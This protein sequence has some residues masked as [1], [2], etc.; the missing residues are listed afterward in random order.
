MLHPSQTLNHEQLYHSLCG[1]W[2]VRLSPGQ[3][4]MQCAPVSSHCRD[5]K[6]HPNTPPPLAVCPT[7]SG[8]SVVKSEFSTRSHNVMQT[9]AKKIR[10]MRR[11]VWNLSRKRSVWTQPAKP[12]Q[13]Q[14]NGITNEWSKKRRMEVSACGQMC[15]TMTQ[16]MQGYRVLLHEDLGVWLLHGAGQIEVTMSIYLQKTMMGQSGQLTILHQCMTA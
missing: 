5:I 14:S 13:D 1:C 10:K 3:S 16:V 9:A 2:G 4:F 7:I 15:S 12:L 6:D 11:S 8:K